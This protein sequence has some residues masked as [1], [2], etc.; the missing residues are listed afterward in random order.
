MHQ[1]PTAFEVIGVIA[2][3]M[4]SIALLTFIGHLVIT[5]FEIRDDV[6]ALTR[7]AKK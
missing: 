1:S 4:A 5:I 6:K 3:V 7:K 2:V